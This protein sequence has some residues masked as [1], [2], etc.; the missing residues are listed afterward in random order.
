MPKAHPKQQPRSDQDSSFLESL[1]SDLVEKPWTFLCFVL[2]AAAI[3]QAWE[4]GGQVACIDYYQFWTIGQVFRQGN[5]T[6]LY[7]NEERQRLG[8]MMWQKVETRIGTDA[9]AQG[10]SKQYQAGAKRQILETYS[11]PFLYSVFGICSTGDY[12]RDQDRFQLFS[13]ICL[14]FGVTLLCHLTGYPPAA[15]AIA[16][17]FFLAVFGPTA[18]DVSVGNVNRIQIALIAVFLWLQ[19]RS[20]RPARY[21]TAGFV[22]GLTILFKPNLLIMALVLILGWA[23]LKQYRKLLWD[24]GGMA[25]GAFAGFLFSAAFCGSWRHWLRWAAEMPRLMNEYHAPVTRGN[26]A[27]SEAIEESIGLNAAIVISLLLM[28]VTLLEFPR[29]LPGRSQS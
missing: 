22:L 27:F 21:F 1:R 26:F 20:G 24:C 10:G 14:V 17:V 8:E 2:A 23:F 4:T 6:D 5:V 7:S 28:V 19:S 29:P 25:A 18:S 16:V 9:N 15:G 13:L 12:D 11:T 3:I